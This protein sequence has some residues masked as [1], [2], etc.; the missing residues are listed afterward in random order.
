[1][2]GQLSMSKRHRELAIGEALRIYCHQ[3]HHVGDDAEPEMFGRL[4]AALAVSTAAA[5][6]SSL[7]KDPDLGVPA[8][9]SASTVVSEIVA[10]ARPA[11]GARKQDSSSLAAQVVKVREHLT[12]NPKNRPGTM[13]K[14]RSVLDSLF[15][16]KLDIEALN[17]LVEELV[18]RKVVLEA[19]GKLT[20]AE[21]KK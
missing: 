7:A 12:N 16:K 6:V 18:R 21:L 13:K 8:T 14:L 2:D 10:E 3:A 9:P 11:S 19:A 20:Y 17:R 15:G 4:D 5:L 1:M